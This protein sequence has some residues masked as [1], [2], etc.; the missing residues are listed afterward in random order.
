MQCDTQI[1]VLRYTDICNAI[2][3]YTQTDRHADI[4]MPIKGDKVAGACIF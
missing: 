2:H 3:R 1:Y 4:L